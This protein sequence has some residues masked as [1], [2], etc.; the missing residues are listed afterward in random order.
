MSTGNFCSTGLHCRKGQKR[1]RKKKGELS[2]VYWGY[3]FYY[4]LV[5]INIFQT[6]ELKTEE[7]KPE[8]YF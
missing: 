8:K 1:K 5:F 4:K 7:T 6:V 3:L 2:V